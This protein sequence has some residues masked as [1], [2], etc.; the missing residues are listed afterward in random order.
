MTI[1]AVV[2]GSV[3]FGANIV[4][5]PVIAVL[6][7]DALP[8]T[9]ALVVIPLVAVM[10]I[11]E[12]HALDRRGVT[13]ITVGRL[14]GTIVGAVVVAAISPDT[15]S[16]LLGGGV[17]L[18]VAMSTLT[19]SIPV[20][21]VTASTAGFASGAMGTATSIGGPPLALLY[22]HHEGPVLRATLA[23]A[24]AVG[25]VLSLT[26]LAIAGAIEAWHVVLAT[27]LL[28]GLLAGL[29]LSRLFVHRLDRAWLRPAVLLFAAA[30]AVI[31]I[32]RGL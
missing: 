18:A 25:T 4:A 26:G 23:V 1:G 24:F 10:A 30:T 9:L 19:A 6:E 20:N 2:Q 5:V 17:L 32:I 14:P 21:R 11:R 3:G 7:P 27:V 22:Q 8:A 13:W 12:R 16:V 15:L 28:P 31:A 29:A